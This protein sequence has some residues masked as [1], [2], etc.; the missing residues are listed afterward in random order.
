[1]DDS[2]EG[3]STPFIEELQVELLKGFSL[4]SWRVMLKRVTLSVI[5]GVIGNHGIPEL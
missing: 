3:I 2:I 5:S 4:P 1:M